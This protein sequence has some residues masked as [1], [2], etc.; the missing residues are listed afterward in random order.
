MYGR[1]HIFNFICNFEAMW[2]SR[3]SLEIMS[4]EVHTSPRGSV[5]VQNTL[6]HF[7]A[8]RTQDVGLCCL[9]IFMRNGTRKIREQGTG[10]LSLSSQVLQGLNKKHSRQIPAAWYWRSSD[11]HFTLLMNSNVGIQK[12]H[13]ARLVGF[14]HLATRWREKKVESGSFSG[15][16]GYF[17][18]TKRREGCSICSIQADVSF[19]LCAKCQTTGNC[20]SAWDWAVKTILWLCGFFRFSIQ[21][22]TAGEQ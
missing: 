10:Q 3:I 14:P 2:R 7:Y 19:L 22:W 17:R 8:Q 21:W 20:G 11:T 13:M 12:Y 9:S 4:K 6:L 1:L 5:I 18:L 16:G 15:I